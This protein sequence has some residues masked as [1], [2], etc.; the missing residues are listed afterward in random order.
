MSV[1]GS[2]IVMELLAVL[3]VFGSITSLTPIYSD[4]SKRTL[5][6]NDDDFMIQNTSSLIDESALMHIYGEVR[7]ISDMSIANV[8]IK[9]SFYDSSGKLLN[10]YQRTCELPT[11]NAG[12]Y[13]HLKFYTL[14][15]K[16]L[17]M[18]R[19]SNYQL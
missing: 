17:I 3:L 18:L 16:Q 19:T 13:V 11:V 12:G 4:S 2:S 6:A 15:Q 9:G 5:S 10:V 14:I 7:N 8:T 1:S